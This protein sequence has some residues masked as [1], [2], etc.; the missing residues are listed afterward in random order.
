MLYLTHIPRPPLAEFVEL[1]WLSERRVAAHAMERCL[2]TGTVELV[3]DLRDDGLR[4]HDR[5]DP[6]KVH[7]FGE[8]LVCGPHAEFFVIDTARPCAIMGVHF[9]PGGA[10]AFFGLPMDELVNL[11]VPLETLWREDAA[12]MRERLL[13]AETPAEKFRS[14]ERSLL[15]RLAR[16]E[17]R[18]AAVAFALAEFRRVPQRRPIGDLAEQ[19]GLSPRRF[20]R[21]FSDEVGLTPKLF[22]RVLR[23]QQALRLINGGEPVDWSELALACGYYDQAHFIHDFQA[24]CGLCPTAYPAQRGEH[25]NH[26]RHRG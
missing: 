5:A 11:H 25:M 18:H 7:D 15:V 14:L 16:R 6:D 26:V 20:I 19:I 2:P 10:F 8:A 13:A 1:L 21:L 24:F 12:R 4:L 17:A 3:I 9:K 22:C 23:F